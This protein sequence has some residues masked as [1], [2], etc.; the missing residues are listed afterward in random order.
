M[1][2]VEKQIES[3]DH[4]LQK[5][6]KKET[7]IDQKKEEPYRRHKLKRH[8]F[9]SDIHQQIQPLFQLNNYMGILAVLRDHFVVAVSIAICLLAWEYSA[10][11]GG[12]T[13]VL[14]LIVIASVMR[15]LADVLH[16]STHM[17]LA[18]N[19][20]L[21]YLLG[22]YFSGYLVFQTYRRYR[23]SH[24]RGH[25]KHLGDVEKD[26]DLKYYASQGLLNIFSKKEFLNK[27]LLPNFFL[28][29][30]P[31]NLHYLITQR[32]LVPDFK[33]QKQDIKNEYYFFIAFWVSIVGLSIYFGLFGYLLLFWIVPYVTTFQMLNCTIEVFEHYPIVVH[34]TKEIYMT[35]NRNGNAL[36]RFLSGVHDENLHLVH[37]L[38]AGIPSWNLRKV[39][40]ILLQ[41][42]EYRFINE[43]CGGIIT[44]SK[45]GGKPLLV[46]M[47][48]PLEKYQSY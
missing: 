38:F 25:H 21:N 43:R 35:R 29:K 39:H 40:N 16:S 8:S 41:D 36:E 3:V 10:I 28:L 18:K 5:K 17:I 4:T 24:C 33:S 37:H 27:Y 23:Q 30:L 47:F 42:E 19:Y 22:T 1:T 12:I 6:Y 32:L 7:G 44:P 31:S 48:E 2:K 15:G 9:S 34:S 11:L 13:Y 26:P 45:I 20:H 14:T 46:S